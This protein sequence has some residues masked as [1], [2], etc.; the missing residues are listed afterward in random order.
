MMQIR[1][2]VEGRSAVERDAKESEFISWYFSGKFQD[3]PIKTLSWTDRDGDHKL[4]FAE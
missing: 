4:I 3:Q 1:I 2:E